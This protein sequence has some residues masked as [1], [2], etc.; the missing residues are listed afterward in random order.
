MCSSSHSCLFIYVSEAKSLSRVRLFETPWTVAYQASPSMGFFR[1][2]YWS[3]LPFPSP[4]DL[5]DPGIEPGSPVLEADALTSEPPFPNSRTWA[6]LCRFLNAV[7]GSVFNLSCVLE[8]KVKFQ[9]SW[10]CFF[11]FYLVLRSSLHSG[12][13]RGLNNFYLL[14]VYWRIFWFLNE[15]A[16]FVSILFI[17]TLIDTLLYAPFY[18]LISEG[19]ILPTS[20][21]CSAY[22]V[23][24]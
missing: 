18:K 22:D 13:K 5:P 9:S 2:E 1:Q 3:R 15:V 14:F 20:G 6:V 4:G 12:N 11:Y 19:K 7:L 21:Y 23:F 10:D 16:A 17:Q 24:D 8:A